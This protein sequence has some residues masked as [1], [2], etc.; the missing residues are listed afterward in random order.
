MK[1]PMNAVYVHTHTSR[2][3]AFVTLCGRY[4]HDRKHTVLYGQQVPRRYGKRIM[5]LYEQFVN[6]H[7][8]K[9]IEHKMNVMYNVALIGALQTLCTSIV[10]LLIDFVL[11]V[12]AV[13]GCIQACHHRSGPSAIVSWRIARRCNCT[14][15]TPFNTIEHAQ[16]QTITSRA[17]VV[18]QF[19]LLLLLLLLAFFFCQLIRRSFVIRT[20]NDR[21][22]RTICL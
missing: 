18:H 14:H 11:F 5:A 6:K 19:F 17:P 15:P 4:M 20:P 22:D 3:L 21:W 9:K 12:G 16:T 7:N 10:L 13:H 1:Q 8:K 2:S